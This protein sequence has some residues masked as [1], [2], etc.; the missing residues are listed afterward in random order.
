MRCEKILYFSV[1]NID[2]SR[3]SDSLVHF[4]SNIL[5]IFTQTLKLN[6]RESHFGSHHG[7]HDRLG[8]HHGAPVG[9]HHGGAPLVRPEGPVVQLGPHGTHHGAP[10][11]THHGAPVGIHHGAQVGTHHGAQVG[12][13]H[14]AQVGNPRGAL[15]GSL[16]GAP[17]GSLHGAQAGCRHGGRNENLQS[18]LKD[19]RSSFALY[20][21]SYVR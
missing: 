7:L 21:I 11:G 8:T 6:R 12:S 3:H 4:I 5:I 20:C 19:P 1:N 9:F 2:P 15:V 16:H 10:V 18:E 17:V 14:G 13:L